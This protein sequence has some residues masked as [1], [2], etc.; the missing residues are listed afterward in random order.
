MHGDARLPN[1]S[2]N[3]VAFASVIFSASLLYYHWEAMLISYVAVRKLSL[4]FTTLEELA[5]NSD[6]KVNMLY[7]CDN[8]VRFIERLILSII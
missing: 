2:S 7:Y 1:L 4:P 8:K 3:R 6:Y 5:D